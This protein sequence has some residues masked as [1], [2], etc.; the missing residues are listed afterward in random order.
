MRKKLLGM[1][2]TFFMIFMLAACSQNKDI[3]SEKLASINIG[4]TE[5]ESF[6]ILGKPDKIINDRETID[7]ELEKA[8]LRMKL[9]PEYLFLPIGEHLDWSYYTEAARKINDL[10]INQYTIKKDKDSE[11]FLFIFVDTSNSKV[12]YIAENTNHSN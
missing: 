6:D 3:D 11:D 9:M 12:V 2:G 5:S 4:M 1:F 7:K 8:D 10:K